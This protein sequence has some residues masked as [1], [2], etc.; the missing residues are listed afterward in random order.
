[1]MYK[2]DP[3]MKYT[4]MCKYIDDHIYKGDYDVNLVYEYL[5]HISNMLAH[6][7]KYFNKQQDYE[8][9]AIYMATNVYLRLTNQKQFIKNDKGEPKLKQIKSVLNYIKKIIDPR[10]VD[11]QQTF[12]AQTMT[13]SSEEGVY[14]DD[15][16]LASKLRNSIEVDSMRVFKDCLGDIILTAKA[17]L[18]RIPYKTNKYEWNNIYLSCLLSFLN[19][20]TLKN[21][22]IKRVKNLSTIEKRVKATEQL[23]I[24]ES[25]DSTILYHL[26]ESMRDYITVL[27][28]SVKHAIAKDISLTIHS[29][30]PTEDNLKNLVLSEVNNYKT[31]NYEEQ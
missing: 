9:F 10:R 18:S 7:G 14:N 6:K 19:S 1:M 20:I 29:C 13:E 30:I 15:Y 5:Y 11:F 28:R 12:Y 23:Y 26:D 21:R 31:S 25:N 8:N 2:K 24:L 16:S 22:D 3:K 17:Y 27:T 4:D